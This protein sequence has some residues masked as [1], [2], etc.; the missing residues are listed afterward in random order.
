MLFCAPVLL[1]VTFTAKLHELPALSAAPAKLTL[2]VPAIAVIV[3]FPQL[4][5]RPLGVD[6]TSPLGRVSVN[7][8][9]LSA[10]LLLGLD[11][12]KVRVV[13]PPRFT[14][15]PPNTFAMVGGNL[16]GGGGVVLEL[17][18]PQ[19]ALQREPSIRHRREVRRGSQRGATVVIVS[20]I[21]FILC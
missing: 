9:P 13:V 3:P 14:P 4:P 2:F 17:P 18:P 10:R 8:I 7:P 21:S 15:A 20:P 5:V 6:T 19:P 16:V 11:R 12:L 1:P